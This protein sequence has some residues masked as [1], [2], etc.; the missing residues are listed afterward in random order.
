MKTAAADGLG[1]APVAQP[2]LDDARNRYD[3]HPIGKPTGCGFACYMITLERTV[4]HPAVLKISQHARDIMRDSSPK[5][6][7]KT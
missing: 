3:L 5:R 1:F 4:R 7:T 2:V 6:K